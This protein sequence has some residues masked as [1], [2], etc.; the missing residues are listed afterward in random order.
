MFCGRQNIAL[1][2]HRD[3][4]FAESSNHGNFKALLSFRVDSGDDVLKEHLF[5]APRNATYT[6]NTIQ[7]Q[8]ISTIGK[9]IQN[10]IVKC[11]NDGSKVYSVIA[12]EGRDCSN[13]EQM[14]FVIRY[15][16]GLNE[17]RE[18]FLAFVECEYGTS[19]E[20]LASLIEATCRNLGLDM[21]LCRGQG[22][23][24]AANMA[25]AC[26]G[27]AKVIQSKYPKSIYFHCASH[28]LNL[29]VVRSCKLTSVSNMMS[30]ITGIANFFNYSP[31]RQKALE[32]QVHELDNTLKTKLLP[33]CRTRWVE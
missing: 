17:I 5:S 26:N 15:T 10:S 18:D 25:G 30:T 1:R 4:S 7:N 19:G 27:A 29:C 31:K 6:S 13:K 8:L 3:S 20:K 21:N 9:W 32:A 28:K 11:I 22:Y 23:D 24:G 2:G 12:D 16:D 14:P 33:L